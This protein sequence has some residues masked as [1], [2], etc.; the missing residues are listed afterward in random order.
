MLE[1]DARLSKTR[2]KPQRH[3]VHM[4]SMFET[5]Q[6]ENFSV[7]EAHVKL[8]ETRV[9]PQRREV[10]M[11]SVSELHHLENSLSVGIKRKAQ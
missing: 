4:K 10:H 6:F 1:S 7:L 9:K 5:P 11:K 8:S 2:V 3:E